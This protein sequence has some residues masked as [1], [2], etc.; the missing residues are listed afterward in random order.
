MHTAFSSS[1]L[2][3]FDNSMASIDR[4]FSTPLLYI[5]EEKR[6][7]K[8]RQLLDLNKYMGILSI[9]YLLQI[10]SEHHDLE[11]PTVHILV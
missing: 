11:L 5:K 1:P 6:Y 7:V 9:F 10:N 4:G 3:Y 8:S 2:S